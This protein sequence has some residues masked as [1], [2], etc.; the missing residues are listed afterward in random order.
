MKHFV[1]QMQNTA[2]QIDPSWIVFLIHETCTL[3]SPVKEERN[4]Q[5]AEGAALHLFKL[6]FLQYNTLFCK[7]EIQHLKIMPLGLHLLSFKR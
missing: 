4:R 5:A 6:Y 1:L 2:P 3:V 7:C